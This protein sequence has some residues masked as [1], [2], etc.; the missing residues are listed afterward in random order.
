VIVSISA[1]GSETDLECGKICAGEE[2]DLSETPN[3][4][5][6]DG[7][8]ITAAASPPLKVAT[9]AG[10]SSVFA[11]PWARLKEHK[12]VQWTLAYAA[13]AFALLHGAT[14]MSDALEWPHT[15]VRVLTLA[16]VAALPIIP[17][18]A[19]YHGVRALKR[20]SGSEL[21]FVALLLAIGGSLLWL[22]PRS[23]VE[24]SARAVASKGAPPSLAR[25]N[26]P[27]LFAPP[28]H[29]IAVLPFVNMSGDS[30]Q[31]Y[32]SDGISEELL[33]ALTRLNDLQV[34]ART[35]SFSFKGKDADVAT[36]A[37]KLNVGAVLEGSVRRAGNTVRITVQLINAVSGFHIWS[38]T[39]DRN[40]TDILKV[41][42]DVA[43]AVAQQLEV[44]L[45]GDVAARIEA[46]G[47]KN[48]A[49]YDAY[50]R[51]RQ[52]LLRGDTDEAGDLANIAAFDQAIALDPGYALA[53]AGRAAAV[54]NF[55]IF[56]AKPAE[57]GSLRDQARAAAERAVALAPQLGG[58][59]VVLGQL[60]AFLLLDYAGA[61]PE[62]ARALALEPGSA[63]V[64]SAF[65]AFSSL[66]GRN[67][68]AI[69]AA[70]RAVVL[71]P[72]DVGVHINLG[73]CL[74]AAHQYA[75]ALAA[76]QDAKA[77]NPSSHY[78]RHS[79]T[80]VL[81]ASGQTQQAL[82]QCESPATGLD[83]DFRHHCLAVA[84]H[85][86]GRRADADRE[87][88]RLRTLNG[89]ASAYGYAQIYAQWGD[90]VRSFQWLTTA[91]R[92]RAPGLMQLKSDW[93]LDPIRDEPEFKAI[94]ARLNF[95]P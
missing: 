45:V 38:Q 24:H 76:L 93:Q 23:A 88:E 46:G 60:R 74:L 75:Q 82:Q 3:D 26:A 86:L 70:R 15:I 51:G 66:L 33:N 56:N 47:T 14:L 73:Q 17:V 49:A 85:A 92:L 55:A 1:H 36:I 95:P 35:S 5:S 67:E 11:N 59:R 29:S 48:P 12:V 64:Q 31:E 90:K 18:L 40:L 25:V 16:L 58:T 87:L 62:F 77:L 19:W 71:N 84:Y 2:R 28:A 37:R 65:A 39:Y 32:F 41:Q 44:K 89:D 10:D 68:L 21:T 81:L 57:Q 78:V 53:Y 54:A 52:M 61:A 69:A 43:T 13:F 20:V 30:K 9:H 27:V 4:P 22:Y 7:K 6:P 79:I 42:T 63:G 91:E 8:G 50:L 83:E 72:L 80:E 34:A 94:A